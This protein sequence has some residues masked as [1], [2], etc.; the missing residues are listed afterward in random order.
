[1]RR[2]WR[3]R[4]AHHDGD[5]EGRRGPAPGAARGVYG[6]AAAFAAIIDVFVGIVCV[7]IVIGIL[8]VVLGANQDNAIVGAIHDVAKFLVGPFADIFERD[9]RKEEVAINWGIAMLV[10]FFIG[11]A[12]AALLRRGSR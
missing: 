11:R 3:R 12:L 9:D 2:F 1:M 8:L 10:Y 4:R 7:I 6:I 5:A